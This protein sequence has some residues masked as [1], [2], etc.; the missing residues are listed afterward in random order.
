MSQRGRNLQWCL[1]VLQNV[2][3][4]NTHVVWALTLGL[5]FLTLFLKSTGA[6][7]AV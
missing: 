2:P 7:E 3:S 4:R 5:S 6:Y 1:M